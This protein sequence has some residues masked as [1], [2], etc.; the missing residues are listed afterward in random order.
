[1][2]ALKK[3]INTKGYLAV[4]FITLIFCSQAN[5]GFREALS[6]L[7]H[8]NAEKMLSEVQAA[9]SSNNEDSFTLFIE[10]LDE[11]YYAEDFVPESVKND[12]L[13]RDYRLPDNYEQLAIRWDGLLNTSQQLRLLSL[14]KKVKKF[15]FPESV[16]VTKRLISNLEKNQFEKVVKISEDNS[17]PYYLSKEK[18][19]FE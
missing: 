7:Q 16:L 12:R 5:A 9:V 3:N 18:T 15:D 14:L 8:R 13:R 1:M 11:Q 19:I 17:T 10:M 2:R 4:Y 6:A